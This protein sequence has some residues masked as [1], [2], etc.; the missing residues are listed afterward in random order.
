MKHSFLLHSALLV[1]IS[2][3]TWAQL[4][5]GTQSVSPGTDQ[6]QAT[7]YQSVSQ[8]DTTDT[9]SVVAANQMFTPPPVSGQAYPIVLSSQERSNFIRGGLAFTGAYT[10]NAL[11]S[12]GAKPV[13]DVSY[14][15]APM[16]SLD[17]TTPREHLGLSYTPG[18]TLYRRLTAF[19]GADQN[20][21]VQFAYR[22]SPH[23]ALSLRD[24]FQKSS[25][26]FNQPNLISLG[27]VN[28]GAGE[29][30]FSVIAPTANVLTNAGS[31]GLTY[32]FAQNQMI[33]ASGTFGNLH[34]PDPSEVPGLY[35]SASQS[36]LAF[37]AVRLSQQQYLGAS[38]QYQRLVAYAGAG[39]TETQT[40]AAFVFYS[41]YPA[42]G[43]SIS[44]FGG[45]QHSDSLL[46]PS[47]PHSRE[48]NP[49]G[50]ASLA[51]QGLR[52]AF[53][54]SYVHTVSSSAGLTGAVELD[55][56]N[57]SITQ[58]ITRRLSGAIGAGYAQN[59]VL[60]GLLTQQNN[61]HSIAGT[62]SLGQQ[63][64]DHLHVQLG[65]SRLRQ[66]YSGVTVLAATPNTNR[67]F[68][69]VSYQFAR[70]LGR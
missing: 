68:V 65:Y 5:A 7:D 12:L 58:Q 13:S 66:N 62:A 4:Q 53:A 54:L 19:D 17:E 15:I 49:A 42:R 51:W 45:P 6:K 24:G 55:G 43:F 2:A 34:Y 39:Q 36:G 28:G 20:V 21:S 22:L 67:E 16:I 30:N 70:A 38:Y 56:A 23:V 46:V 1:V 25:S 9:A 60:T 31:T 37:Y 35:D 18:Y 52:N 64:G 57:G 10:D 11:G 29:P 8:S 59:S 33:G 32:Q 3:P 61:G 47:Q 41:A 48:W 14:S 50:G 69:S 40:H 44:F 63:F 27:E 26:V